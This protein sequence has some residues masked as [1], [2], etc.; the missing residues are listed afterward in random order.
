MP[1]SRRRRRQ[2][3]AADHLETGA[4]M[5]VVLIASAVA[6]AITVP[7]FLHLH[8]SRVPGA[9]AFA[10]SAMVASVHIA[11]RAIGGSDSRGW[12]DIVFPLVMLL[13][14]LL[15]L[16]G[17]RQF[18]SKPAL[19]PHALVAILMPVAGLLAVFTFMVDSLAGRMIV[20]TGSAS[21]IVL[22]MAWTMI[23][24]FRQADA[25]TA[26]KLFAIVC[27]FV[28]SAFFMSRWLAAVMGTDS[29]SYFAE[30]TAWNLAISSMRLLLFPTMYLSAL[31]LL[32][33]RTVTRLE[34]SL[35]HD[36]LTG[37][38]SRRAFLENAAPHFDPNRAVQGNVALLFLD[39][40][41]FK[42]LNDRYGHD[43]GDR[44]LRHFVEVTSKALPSQARLG[45]LGGEE[46][47][48]L[49]PA[50]AAAV[51]TS[52]S[53]MI[54]NALRNAPLSSVEESIPMTVS[55]GV[56]IARPGDST[57]EILKRADEALYQA[58]AN[59]RDQVCLAGEL[60]GDA[61]DRNEKADDGGRQDHVPS[62]FGAAY[63]AR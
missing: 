52:V 38:L 2:L 21:I 39:I 49:L 61:A 9:L 27:A 14:S 4:G 36:S 56:A 19:R 11:L 60:E 43:T 55:I 28:V 8:A 51:A 34:R 1:S 37:A 13:G 40:D 59:G 50:S 33:G 53:K 35:N 32:L 23:D 16:S 3:A 45:R 47:A 5:T 25:P 29:W 22:A 15:M 7:I 63:G 20:S 10:A 42:Q 41:H 62:I 46:F 57:N 17:F 54:L 44:A 48:I 30:P 26:F 18:V 31:L 24:G 58:K 6:I 12:L